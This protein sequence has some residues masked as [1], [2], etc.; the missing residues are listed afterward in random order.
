MSNFGF[1]F[2]QIT[3]WGFIKDLFRFRP[4]NH[5]DVSSK[6]RIFVGHDPFGDFGGGLN[7]FHPGNTALVQF[8]SEKDQEQEGGEKK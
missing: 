7:Q 2:T 3:F 4:D 1:P 6:E 8:L 5:G